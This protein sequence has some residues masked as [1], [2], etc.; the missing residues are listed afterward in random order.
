MKLIVRTLILFALAMWIGGVLFFPIVVSE[1]LRS[2]ANPHITGT[3][4]GRGFHDL[5]YEGIWVG[6][7]FLI[8][9]YAAHKFRALP[10]SVLPLTVVAVGLL[11]L[12]GF[13]QFWIAPRIEHA[14][15]A[16]EG[17]VRNAPPNDPNQE[18]L[19]KLR[20]ASELL[21]IAL[22]VGGITLMALLAWNF[23]A[24]PRTQY[25]AS[26]KEY[27]TDAGAIHCLQPTHEKS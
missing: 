22:A 16:A 26:S 27:G 6:I 20:Y 10:R 11:V 19:Q 3:I 18:P 21:E 4:I 7:A 12:T 14:R 5:H 17:A 13:S 9:L 2:G 24:E 23:P 8:L 25:S 1:V 15:L